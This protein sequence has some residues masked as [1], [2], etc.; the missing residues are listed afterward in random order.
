MPRELKIK[1]PK[2]Q[3]KFYLTVRTK[4]G[5]DAAFCNKQPETLVMV[6]SSTD[7]LVEFIENDGSKDALYT[8][9]KQS[10]GKQIEYKEKWVWR[11]HEKREEK[12]GGVKEYARENK[13]Y[14]MVGSYDYYANYTCPCCTKPYDTRSHTLPDCLKSFS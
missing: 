3:S 12:N 11:N 1:K 8:I 10:E 2:S 7:E 14:K 9:Y 6:G 5:K 4:L 13:W